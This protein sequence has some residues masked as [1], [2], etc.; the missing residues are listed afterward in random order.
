MSRCSQVF[1]VFFSRCENQSCPS[2]GCPLP[3]VSLPGCPLQI[4]FLWEKKRKTP[5]PQ[6]AFWT[7]FHP[8]SFVFEPQ[9]QKCFFCPVLQGKVHLIFKI[10]SQINIVRDFLVKTLP[11]FSGLSFS[12]GLSSKLCSSRLFS[13]CSRLSSL[14]VVV[15]LQVVLHRCFRHRKRFLFCPNSV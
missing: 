5:E 3:G 15:L 14:Q 1:Q 8:F 7:I 2:S 4:V 12:S 9:I 13:S 6:I 11:F 10:A